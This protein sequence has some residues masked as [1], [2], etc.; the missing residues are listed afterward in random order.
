MGRVDFLLLGG[1]DRGIDYEPL[2]EYLQEHPVPHLLFTGNAGERMRALLKNNGIN[3]DV[4]LYGSMEEAF[5]YLTSHAQNG[6][7]CLLSPAA[8]SYD[9]YKNFEERGRKFKDLAQQ[10]GK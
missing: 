8:A 3:T 1:F 10:F 4:Q 6:D 5:A 2:A 7:V 9:Q